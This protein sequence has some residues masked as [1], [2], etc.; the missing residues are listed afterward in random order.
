MHA[1]GR[2]REQ[3]YQ[4]FRVPGHAGLHGH[5]TACERSRWTRVHDAEI[6]CGTSDCTHRTRRT[7]ARERLDGP[8]ALRDS[9][10]NG[11]SDEDRASRV[12]NRDTDDR[13]PGTLLDHCAS[14]A[15]RSTSRRSRCAT[16]ARVARATARMYRAS[17]ACVRIPGRQA[18]LDVASDTHGFNSNERE[19]RSPMINSSSSL[20]SWRRIQTVFLYGHP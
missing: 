20:C 16:R 9:H 10:N 5:T 12:L 13:P 14:V 8:R 6:R 11:M 19:D 3:R 18:R 4:G 1:I 7:R 2:F 15:A 17:C